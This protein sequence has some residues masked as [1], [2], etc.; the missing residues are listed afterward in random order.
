MIIVIPKMAGTMFC[1]IT[2]WQ[3]IEEAPKQDASS[4]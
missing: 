2:A 1:G 3:K 4:L